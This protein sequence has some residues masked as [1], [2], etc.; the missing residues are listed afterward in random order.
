MSFFCESLWRL[1]FILFRN[2]VN[3]NR[4]IFTVWSG[5][6]SDLMN[7]TT[8]YEMRNTQLSLLLIKIHF[9]SNGV[10]YFFHPY[11][12]G[13]VLKFVLTFVRSLNKHQTK[14]YLQNHFAQ[15]DFWIRAPVL[16]APGL[17]GFYSNPD[18]SRCCRMV[19]RR[20]SAASHRLSGKFKRF[21]FSV[22]KLWNHLSR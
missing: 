2:D 16:H 5:N 1:L 8:S 6:G 10:T 4:P 15:F 21:L 20:F 19:F 14:Y 17:C 22:H 7:F 11:F 9:D 3:K 12:S 18:C 13:R